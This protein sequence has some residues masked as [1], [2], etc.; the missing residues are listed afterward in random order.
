MD[1][2]LNLSILQ[3]ALFF[4]GAMILGI[5]IRSYFAGRRKVKPARMENEVAD[6]E[7]EAWEIKYLNDMAVRDND[8]SSLHQ[9]LRKAKENL[10]VYSVRVEELREKNSRFEPVIEN[11]EKRVKDMYH[12]KAFTGYK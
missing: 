7:N 1:I 3:M 4:S 5:T 11:L 10:K 12:K 8:L 6:P 2:N 9:Q